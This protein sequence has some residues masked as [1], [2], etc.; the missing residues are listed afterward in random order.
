MKKLIYDGLFLA[1]LG[2]MF[3]RCKKETPTSFKAQ[4]SVSQ[5]K[6]ANRYRTENGR[7]VFNSV[8]DYEISVSDLSEAQEATFV[9]SINGLSYTSYT[10]EL[11]NQGPTATDLIGDNVLSAILNKG[12][13]VQIANHLYKVNIQSEKVFVLPVT[14]IADY[15]DLV[16]ENKLNKNIRQFSAGDDVI[17]LAE[18]GDPGEKCGGI[19]GSERTSDVVD[20]GNNIRCQASVKHFRAG[21]YFRTTARFVPLTAGILNTD[22]EVK[23]PEAWA[24]KRPCNAGSVITSAPGVKKSGTTQQLWQFYSGTRNLNG[25]YLFARVKCNYNG[26]VQY[27]S[28]CGRNVNSPH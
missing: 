15:N 21:V 4:D 22:L 19:N 10:E 24:R 8:E 28:W 13:I 26:V 12:R 27:S 9:S 20:F 14:K 2:I 11:V 3:V 16:N 7:L 6:N 25:L 17:Y 5:E 1:S 18:S 23:G